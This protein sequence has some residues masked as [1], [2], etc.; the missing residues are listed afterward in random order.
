MVSRKLL[1]TN[2]KATLT[3]EEVMEHTGRYDIETFARGIRGSYSS[4]ND[5]LILPFF[6]GK[7]QWVCLKNESGMKFEQVWLP[8]II[9]WAVAGDKVAFVVH[10]KRTHVKFLRFDHNNNLVPY[11]EFITAKS[12]HHHL[13]KNGTLIT[14]D[15]FGATLAILPHHILRVNSRGLGKPNDVDVLGDKYA[16]AFENGIVENVFG[17]HT[18][19]ILPGPRKIALLDNAIILAAD[20]QLIVSHATGNQKYEL[21]VHAA[22]GDF[23]RTPTGE[24]L[25]PLLRLDGQGQIEVG[26][27]GSNGQFAIINRVP[28]PGGQNVMPSL[29]DV[30]YT[31]SGITFAVDCF[32][33]IAIIN[34]HGYNTL[35]LEG[36]VFELRLTYTGVAI[37]GTADALQIG[38]LLPKRKVN[39][40]GYRMQF[41]YSKR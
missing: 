33:A 11:D 34:E 27:V 14:T 18:H 2:G 31:A 28:V 22:K 15:A 16:V 1:T 24:V 17:D 3:I 41:V 9:D 10:D 8:P 37:V 4:P 21:P 7:T 26:V 20:R 12:V 30:R 13:S 38:S 5:T 39:T 6:L 40:E 23:V 36:T 29:L 25:L 35:P 32:T 19:T